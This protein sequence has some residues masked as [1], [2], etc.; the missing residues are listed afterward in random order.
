MKNIRKADEMLHLHYVWVGA[1]LPEE[2][3][4]NIRGVLYGAKLSCQHVCVHVWTNNPNIILRQMALSDCL[5]LLNNYV[6]I[7]NI[8]DLFLNVKED[9]LKKLLLLIRMEM[10]G[11]GAKNLASVS[12]MVRP[13]ILLLQV[14]GVHLYI[15]TDNVFVGHNV[16]NV[17]PEGLFPQGLDALKT[18]D[19]AASCAIVPMARTNDLIAVRYPGISDE[20]VVKKPLLL[21]SYLHSMVQRYTSQSFLNVDRMKQIMEGL[22]TNMPVLANFFAASEKLNTFKSKDSFTRL[23]SIENDLKRSRAIIPIDISGFSFRMFLTI[24]KTGPN[25]FN[26]V[27]QTL[28]EGVKQEIVF[29]NQAN[30]NIDNHPDTKQLPI[31]VLTNSHRSWVHSSDCSGSIFFVS[32]KPKIIEKR[33]LYL[34]FAIEQKSDG[35]ELVWY[36]C[37][38]ASN[39]PSVFAR[40]EVTTYLTETIERWTR[41]NKTVCCSKEIGKLNRELQKD[42]AYWKHVPLNARPADDSIECIPSDSYLPTGV[43]QEM[44]PFN[45]GPKKS[46][47]ACCSGMFFPDVVKVKSSNLCPRQRVRL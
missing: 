28:D 14:S 21:E 19:N 29:F 1:V 23:F 45:T 17:T 38:G 37:G 39:E 27:F 11:G 42:P 46:L 18:T 7:E 32:Q 40:Q 3:L 25:C 30:E 22:H 43:E 15:D 44:T 9:Y 8:N 34:Y 13:R 31:N 24:H 33:T 4:N 26:E 35:N 10:V 36:I 16:F 6:K 5:F 12:D 2:Y 20:T 41:E 47:F